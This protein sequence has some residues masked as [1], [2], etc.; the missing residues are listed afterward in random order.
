L[1]RSIA[2]TDRAASG[3][4]VRS[5]LGPTWLGVPAGL[6]TALSLRDPTAVGLFF[7]ILALGLY[8]FSNPSRWNIYNHFVLQADAYIHGSFAIPLPKFQDVMPLPDQPG[9]GIIPF[10]PLPAIVLVPL[11]LIFGLSTDVSLVAVILGAINVGLCWRMLTRV[12]DSSGANFLATLFFAFGTVHWYAAMLGSTWF[13]A[14]IVAIT[15]LLLAIT[16]AL[17]GERQ[18]RARALIR[19]AGALV[20]KRGLT[21]IV[22]PLQFLAGFVF[23]VAALARLSVIFGAPFFVFVGGGGSYWRRAF[24]AGL[25]AAIPLLLFL[26]YNLLSTGHL[27]NPAYDWLYHHEYLGY[28]PPD[29]TIDTSLGIEDPGHI[30]TNLLIMFGWPPVVHPEC[31]PSLL[32]PPPECVVLKPDQV[33]MSLLLTSPAY[34]LIA[35]IVAAAWRQRLVLGSALAVVVIATVNLMHFSQGWVQ[36][37]Y[38]FSNDF[39]PFAVIL[40][41]LAIAW[42]GVRWLSLGLVA[43]SIAVNAWGVYWGV[44]SGW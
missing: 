22:D 16:A 32:S 24:S 37:G 4:Q 44:V 14:H 3:T 35:P 21:G 27:F 13:F 23:G 38:R 11:V 18:E 5:R 31:W 26:G 30:P 12:T 39:A 34:M 9:F 29:L 19:Q 17:D 41:A 43:V 33:G 7:L 1:E 6:R 2:T 8:L 42:L 20:R 25:G 28:M 15:F 10:P 36:F 40:V